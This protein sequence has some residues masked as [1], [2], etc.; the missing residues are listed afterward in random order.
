MNNLPPSFSMPP[1]QNPHSY[2]RNLCIEFKKILNE[3]KDIL[4]LQKEMNKLLSA[5]KEMNWKEEKL[6]IWKKNDGKKAIDKVW[7]E[8]KRYIHDL[9]TSKEKAN[10]QDLLDAIEEIQRQVSNL[11]IT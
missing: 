1:G 2:Y 7:Y 10:T 6:E 9:Q 4:I 8:F 3:T 11:D 5:S